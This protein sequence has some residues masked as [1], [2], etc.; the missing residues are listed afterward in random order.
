MM[1]M[2]MIMT[3]AAVTSNATSTS[4]L[5]IILVFIYLSKGF[6]PGWNSPLPSLRRRRILYKFDTVL[7]CEPTRSR[8]AH[9]DRHGDSQPA[10]WRVLSAFFIY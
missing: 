7:L 6:G 10:R 1:C 8:S 4:M 3:A 9:A 2:Y 5:Y